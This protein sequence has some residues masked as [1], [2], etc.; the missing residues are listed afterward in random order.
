M[1]IQFLLDSISVSKDGI[2]LLGVLGI[3]L[4]GVLVNIH[5][6]KQFQKEFNHYNT[7][8]DQLYLSKSDTEHSLTDLQKTAVY[9]MRFYPRY[10][11]ITH[12]IL[13]DWI[14]RDTEISPV[15]KA[16]LAKLNVPYK[17]K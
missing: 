11:D 5:K 15:A 13:T 14:T 10:K 9:E 6:T 17:A 4:A 3:G 16:T 8:V 7:L 2:I 1:D 12:A